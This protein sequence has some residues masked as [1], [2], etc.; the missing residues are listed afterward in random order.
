M[1]V[2]EAAVSAPVTEAPVSTPVSEPVSP[3]VSQPVPQPAAGQPESGV[4]P[5]ASIDPMDKLREAIGK[6]VE[7]LNKPKE[8]TPA[9]QS[10]AGE[11]TPEQLAAE[12]TAAEK[13]E[14]DKAAAQ[15]K[16]EEEK[17][18]EAKAAE[19]KA[20]AEA[21]KSEPNPLDSL[22][23]LPVTALAKAVENP[24][25]AAALEK[26]GIDPEQLYETSRQAALTEQF[27][28]HFP[29]PEAAKFGSQSAEHFYDL[30]EQF[31]KIHSVEDF[32]KFITGTL[33]PLSVV[34]GQDG[35]PLMNADGRG[36]QTD[37]SIERFLTSAVQ[38]DTIG[39]VAAANLL[40]KNYANVP[41][42]EGENLR[43]EAQR[44]KDALLLS[45]EFRDNGGKLP[46]LKPQPGTVDPATQ[47]ELERLRKEN[48]EAKGLKTEAEK[49]ADQAY[50]TSVTTEV[51][52]AGLAFV[53]KTLDGSALNDNEKRLIAEKAV[54]EALG[55]MGKNRH[56]QMQ[57]NNLYSLGQSE[58]NKRQIIALG[59]T[60]FQ[61][62]VT[63]SLNRL[64]EEAGG[65]LLGKQSAKQQK[66]ES[67]IA[68]D[69][70]NQG[71]GTTAGSGAP[72]VLT[73]AQVRLKAIENYKA[74]NKG[75]SPDD[76]QIMQEVLKIR[77]F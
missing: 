37:G 23:P 65:K 47:A 30:E 62:A 27:Q 17:A 26:V 54:N 74:A 68:K 20:K 56:Y 24:E 34:Y 52:N 42:E 39:A 1:P 59:K 76:G 70:M 43:A 32:D 69:K 73:P 38:H 53:E 71:T 33:L 67:Q 46:S 21:A 22:G 55:E 63:K 10:A 7:E 5:G 75:E 77:G 64:V 6:S 41:G 48:Q 12:K 8:V 19:D 45:A 40:I 18:A 14:A 3:T 31:P 49:Q 28:E 50:Q 9:A 16:T 58:E 44:V 13:A 36:Y 15:P 66:Q 25:F 61:Q 4:K 57:K 72:P 35:K 51:S 29:T 60:T 2:E 11:K